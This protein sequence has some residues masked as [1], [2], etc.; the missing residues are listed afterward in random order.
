MTAPE[1]ENRAALEIEQF[2]IAMLNEAAS[3]VHKGH[4]KREGQTAEKHVKQILYHAQKL[5]IAIE[6]DNKEAILEYAADVANHAM[7]AADISDAL[8]AELSP[9]PAEGE[10]Y[11]GGVPWAE[12]LPPIKLATFNDFKR[13]VERAREATVI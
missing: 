13:F 1:I 3:N 6:F 8:G 12:K 5:L 9:A 2:K 11:E 7:F 4:W 10:G